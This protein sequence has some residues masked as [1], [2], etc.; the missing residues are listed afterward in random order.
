MDGE[1]H[2]NWIG[3]CNRSTTLLDVVQC[4]C[5]AI[6]NEQKPIQNN[7]IEGLGPLP[8]QKCAGLVPPC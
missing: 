5:N 7:P 3:L 6:L 8:S 4:Q 2:H 1:G